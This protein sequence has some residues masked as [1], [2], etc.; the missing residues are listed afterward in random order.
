[1][2]NYLCTLSVATFMLMDHAVV[3]HLHVV[4][5]IKHSLKH[6]WNIISAILIRS[7]P[8]FTSRYSRHRFWKYG[9]QPESKKK[10]SSGRWTSVLH[11]RAHMSEHVLEWLWRHDHPCTSHGYSCT[12]SLYTVRQLN[13]CV[14]PNNCRFLDT[15]LWYNVYHIPCI[16]V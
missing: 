5:P 3:L 2:W 10:Q 14:Q 4:H 12:W 15:L 16:I 9:L 6:V 1:M 11:C 13:A 7:P 8:L